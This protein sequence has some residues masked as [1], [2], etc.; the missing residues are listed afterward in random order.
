M[1]QQVKVFVI[2]VA[3]A[4][5]C[6]PAPARAEAFFVPWFGGTFSRS[7]EIR[8]VENGTTSFGAAVG[9][10]SG[11]GLLA[12]D[13]DFGFTPEFFG[14]KA[15]VGS[16]N[17]I[18]VTGNLI[19]G[20]SI[21]TSGGRGVRPYGNFGIGLIRSKAGSTAD[22]AFG[23]NAAGGLMG[24]FTSKIGVRGDVR[25]FHTVNNTSAT[26]TVLLKPGKFYF[27]RGYVGLV[28]R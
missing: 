7:S 16:N 14:S 3:V 5:V 13:L 8:D 6:T 15:A 28:I 9:S 11:G 20:P 12:F 2:A 19:I 23:W 1:R 27:W 24:F 22:N 26:N 17:V 25:Y 10:L 21:E 4:F 18:T